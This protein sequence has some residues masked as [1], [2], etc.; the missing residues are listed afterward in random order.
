MVDLKIVQRGKS[1][2]GGPAVYALTPQFTAFM[3][4]AK[5]RYLSRADKLQ[6]LVMSYVNP[7][8]EGSLARAQTIF[9]CLTIAEYIGKHTDIEVFRLTFKQMEKM[10]D[11]ILKIGEHMNFVKDWE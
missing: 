5:E 6:Q 10:A 11:T 7:S 2:E 9:T 3:A 8:E 4:E 1:K